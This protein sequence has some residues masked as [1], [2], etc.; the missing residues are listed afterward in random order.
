MDKETVKM[1]KKVG[2]IL[3]ALIIL[4][5]FVSPYK[6]CVRDNLPPNYCA[7]KSAW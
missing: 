6:N 2:I 5:Y 7:A 1:I 3:I 4:Y